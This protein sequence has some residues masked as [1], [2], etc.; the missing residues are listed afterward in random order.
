[1]TRDDVCYCIVNGK[2]SSSRFRSMKRQTDDDTTPEEA[3]LIFHCLSNIPVCSCGKKLTFRSFNVGYSKFCSRKCANTDKEQIKRQNNS[4]NFCE[5]GRKISDMWSNKTHDEMCEKESKRKDTLLERYGDENYNNRQQFKETSLERYGVDNPM[6]NKDVCDGVME[7]Q[8]RLY[9]GPFHP[10]KTAETNLRRYGVRYP[11]QSKDVRDKLSKTKRDKY[12]DSKNDIVGVVYF[13]RMGDIIKVG[14]SEDG[15]F[16][17]R[18]RALQRSYSEDIE[19]IKV[20]ESEDVYNLE[21]R[22][23]QKFDEYNIVLEE[24]TGRT[25]WFSLDILTMIDT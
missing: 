12:K 14:V 2:F 5:I 10:K 6:K 20:I 9:N 8:R 13:I 19:V 4:K 17:S 16:K 11:A 21:S 22:Y 25:E 7:T 15:N 1:M 23:H 24:G 3:Y 18:L